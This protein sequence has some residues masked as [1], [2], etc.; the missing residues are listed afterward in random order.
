MR[1]IRL[2][3]TGL[4]LAA[5]ALSPCAF[6]DDDDDDDDDRRKGKRWKKTGPR[7]A[8]VHHADRRL[9]RDLAR[10]VAAKPRLPDGSRIVLNLPRDVAPA[11]IAS[12]PRPARVVRGANVARVA[13]APRLARDARYAQRRASAVDSYLRAHRAPPVPPRP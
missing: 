2:L 3:A 9:E 13:T 6:A 8:W 1:P 5:L 11:R 4:A 7:H 12:V 10:L